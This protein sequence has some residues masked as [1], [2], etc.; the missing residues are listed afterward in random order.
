MFKCLD[1]YW[2]LFYIGVNDKDAY[3]SVVGMCDVFYLLLNDIF[4]KIK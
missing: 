3:F 1:F 4:Y 2:K